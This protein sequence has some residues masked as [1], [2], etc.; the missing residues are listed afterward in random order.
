MLEIID[1]AIEAG[2]LLPA[3]RKGACDWC[4]FKAVCGPWEEIRSRRKDAL[5]LQDLQALRAMR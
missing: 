2:S 1:R 5:P 3:P 4:D